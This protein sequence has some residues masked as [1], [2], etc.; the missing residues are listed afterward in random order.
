MG[1]RGLNTHART[2]TLDHHSDTGGDRLTVKNPMVGSV[3]GLGAAVGE[4]P[5]LSVA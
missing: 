5:P 4:M 2:H 1:Y 3:C